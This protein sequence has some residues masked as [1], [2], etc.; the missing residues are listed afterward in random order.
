MSAMDIL[1]IGFSSIVQRRVIPALISLPEVGRISIASRRQVTVEAI[2]SNKRGKVYQG[3]SNA[4]S[5]CE[6]CL[7][8]ISLPNSL[9]AEWAHCALEAGFHV[10]IDKPAVTDISD[11]RELV[12]VAEQKAMCLSESNVWC[13][14][15]LTQTLKGV[16]DKEESVPLQISATFS[17]PSL[18]PGDFRY[19]PDM[20]CGI[21]LDRG[22]YA[23]SCGR[24]F[25][26]GPPQEIFCRVASF[27][28][29][30]K[31]DIYFDVMMGYPGGSVF[32]GFFSLRAEYRNT[33]S[34]IGPSYYLDV[35]R[36][37]KPPAD[38]NGR[39]NVRRN[40]QAEIIPVPVADT[41][42]L[43]IKHVL[44]SIHNGSFSRFSRIL[45]E[46]AQVL[47]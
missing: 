18:N 36:I 5:E 29:K 12:R 7:A 27:D 47:H 32:Q 15:P 8:Y 46:D 30:G 13:Y 34:I 4:I 16:I 25:F 17:S 3:Y 20:G 21:L 24:F 23:V 14:H 33:L 6:P 26:G 39:I 1:I 2:P 37:F 42:A 28:R 31:V 9:H 38:Y 44:N 22:P 11:A 41:F 35:D 40:N 10:I 45:L 43:F 19:N